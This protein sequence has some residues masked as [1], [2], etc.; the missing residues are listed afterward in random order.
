MNRNEYSKSVG[1]N[2]YTL[3]RYSKMPPHQSLQCCF[4]C[5]C[6]AVSITLAS[7]I[8]AAMSFAIIFGSCRL[9]GWSIQ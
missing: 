7:S 3:M 9:E 8:L 6:V 2:I 5:V 1:L 4:F